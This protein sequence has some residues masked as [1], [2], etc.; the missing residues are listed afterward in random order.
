MWRPKMRCFLRV[1]VKRSISFTGAISFGQPGFTGKAAGG[2][3]C[4]AGLE[5]RG[6]TG[7]WRGA[8]REH[9]DAEKGQD[10]Q[11]LE[12]DGL[13]I[14]VGNLPADRTCCKIIYNWMKLDI[15][16]QER[17]CHRAAGRVC[18]RRYTDKQLRQGRDCRGGRGKCGDI[19]A[20]VFI[21]PRKNVAIFRRK[22]SGF[23]VL[24]CENHVHEMQEAISYHQIKMER[25]YV[26]NDIAG[27]KEC[28]VRLFLP[29][30]FSEIASCK[31]K[32]L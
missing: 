29:A 19:C 9:L 8:C 7:Q 32:T 2:R 17:L 4:R 15:F 16:R 30:F 5:H 31:G 23:S 1:A 28:F 25:L 27:R 22:M 18:C 11:L 10:R 21:R 3:K 24:S 12:V 20:G 13:F 14:A 26:R 6:D